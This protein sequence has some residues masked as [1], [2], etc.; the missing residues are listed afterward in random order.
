MLNHFRLGR[1]KVVACKAH[2]RGVL[3]VALAEYFVNLWANYDKTFRK[4]SINNYNLL[5]FVVNLI[6]DGRH[7]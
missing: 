5:T 4:D 3:S 7:S 1:S 2:L 6:Q